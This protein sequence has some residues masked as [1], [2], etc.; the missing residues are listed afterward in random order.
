M[1]PSEAVLGGDE[2]GAIS[3]HANPGLPWR[4]LVKMC[5][6]GSLAPGSS[7]VLPPHISPSLPAGNMAGL[8]FPVSVKV[9]CDR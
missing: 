4:E 2:P 6:M 8:P 5:P 9:R 1:A 3:F 7:S